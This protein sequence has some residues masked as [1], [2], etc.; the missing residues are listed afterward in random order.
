MKT[1]NIHSLVALL[2]TFGMLT[3]SSCRKKEEE[4]PSISPNNKLSKEDAE[5]KLQ[6]LRQEEKKLMQK[7]MQNKKESIKQP[8]K[9]W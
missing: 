8:E 3:F 6:A 2:I 9:D 5:Q 7:L 4:K 1:K